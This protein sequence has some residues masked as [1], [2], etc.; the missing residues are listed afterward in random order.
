M[1]P[2]T[3]PEG[4]AKPQPVTIGIWAALGQ[5]M[6]YVDRYP[7]P[8]LAILFLILV[9][10]VFA[11]F[12]SLSPQ[13]MIDHA[14]GPHDWS[15]LVIT[16]AGLCL[17]FCLVTASQ[18]W[19]DYLYAWLGARVLN[20]LRTDILEH[21]QILSLG[22]F[23]RARLGDLLSR[24]ST[25]LGAVENAIVFGIATSVYAF[26][27]VAV[28]LLVLFVLEWRLAL[29]V[30]VGLPLCL[31]GP[32]I[33]GPRAVS[34]GYKFRTEQAALAST[35]EEQIS[36][37]PVIKAFDLKE[38][39]RTGTSSQAARV[40]A[41]GSRFN[42]LSSVAERSPNMAMLA[43]GILIIVGAAIMAFNGAL[44]VAALISFNLLFVT[45]ST[46]VES[47]TAAVPTLLQAAGGIQRINEIFAEEPAILEPSSP[48]P[49]PRLSAAI[50][51][52]KV[53]F[54]Y[55][56]YNRNLI[57][58]SVQ[59]PA[60]GKVAFV[61]PSGC[62]KSTIV[63]LL[64]R[65]YDP[66]SG[67][68]LFDGIDLR[69][70][71]LSSLYGQVGIVFQENFLFNTSIRENIRL[72]RPSASDADVERAARAAEL[73]EK[74]FGPSG[75][76]TIVG[77]RGGRLSGGQRQ[78][79]AIARAL[80]RDPSIFLLDE[81]TSSLDPPAA[82]AIN[83]LLAQLTANRTVIAVTHRLEDVVAFDRIFVL[84][85]GRIVE[86]GTHEELLGQNGAYAALWRKE[87]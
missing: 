7:R 51:F 79:V 87:N 80:I 67:Q 72:G 8:A 57:D 43:L 65:F 74:A 85:D 73:D 77:E 2:G 20:D 39:V 32:R 15:M 16:I 64:M 71:R 25:D 84:R 62:G 24:F 26:L 35:I 19:R 49:L 22:F 3:M 10:V 23:A 66:Q 86:R 69:E 55:A 21:L 60:G 33:F 63:N 41:L 37:Q 18:V 38:S 58:I 27:H 5:I 40:V 78:R 70:A 56:P 47:L 28:S 48:L 44:S 61:G 75:Y 29:V 82:A 12:L 6:A 17:G 11:T 30:L 31:I 52:D 81:A 34:A 4:D 76:G 36:A 59:I 53:N 42:F 14:I 68:V 13:L 1:E 50:V 46:Y 54:S 45:V 9:D 83:R